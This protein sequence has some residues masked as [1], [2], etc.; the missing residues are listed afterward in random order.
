MSK[1]NR[2]EI[3]GGLECSRVRIGDDIRDQ[4]VDTGHRNRPQDLQLIASLGIKT[5]RYPVLWET[6]SSAPGGQDFSW[7][8]YQLGRLRAAGISPIVGLV[9]H[10]SGPGHCDILDP[11]FP[12]SLARHARDV[13]LRY[14]W[15]ER[16]TP[17]NE[18]MTT[19]RL[20]GLYGHWYPHG[21]DEATCFR[22]VVSECR[23]ISACMKELRRVSPTAKL[24]QTEDIGRVF[25]TESLQYQADYENERRW[26]ALDLLAGR[27][28][29]G[30]PFHRR[31]LDHG[32]DEGHLEE[33]ADHPCIPDIIGIDHYLTSDRFLDER[34][35]RHP[36]DVPGGNGRDSYVDIAAAR[37]GVPECE[38]GF[39]PRICEAWE[40]YGLP[41]AL[42]EVHNGC[43]REEQLRWLMDGWNAANAARNLSVDVRAVAVWSLFGSTDWNSL[44][45]RRDG[46]YEPGAFDI[47][48]DPPRPTVIASAALALAR[49]GSFDH[50]ALARSGWWR[51]DNRYGR[52][53]PIEVS[54]SGGLEDVL[55]ECCALRRLDMAE[56]TSPAGEPYATIQAHGGSALHREYEGEPRQLTLT[57]HYKA[58]AQDSLVV[59]FDHSI[60]AAEAIH[61]F[62]DLVIDGTCGWFRVARA[63]Q[64][65]QLAFERVATSPP[66][67]AEVELYTRLERPFDVSTAA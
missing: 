23:A 36:G 56:A 41:L 38:S 29:N 37:A 4:I 8:D 24:I 11:A 3:W 22:I 65:Q 64:S 26:L 30:H 34:I 10:G 53:Q 54:S 9:H 66:V 7:H 12:A 14:P 28:S 52:P 33:L 32:V 43:T 15:L 35:E 25:A 31:L 16:F 21:R 27:V 47:R 1:I 18:P 55:K 6:V 2:L 19:A 60:A 20:C 39:L 61:A 46:F 50:P 42:T 45:T 48:F 17:I 59:Q 58:L 44:L 5:L 51:P 67:D 57:C 13:A 49:S 62:L 40:R 63:G